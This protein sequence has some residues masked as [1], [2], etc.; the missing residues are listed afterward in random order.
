M[1]MTV[2]QESISFNKMNMPSVPYRNCRRGCPAEFV[3]MSVIGVCTEGYVVDMASS[4]WNRLFGNRCETVVVGILATLCNEGTA[5]DL[6]NV[7]FNGTAHIS[8]IKI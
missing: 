5:D 2:C 8:G 6:M 1:D 4:A 7:L 3:V